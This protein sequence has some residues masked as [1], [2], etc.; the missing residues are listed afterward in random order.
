VLCHQDRLLCSFFID[1]NSH[2]CAKKW[3]F[4]GVKLEQLL[5][6]EVA[7]RCFHGWT[8][9]RHFSMIDQSKLDCAARLARNHS[10]LAAYNDAQL[11]C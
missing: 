1:V 6:D 7:E 4:A 5:S 11:A 8:Q 2:L 9:V 3:S 10:T